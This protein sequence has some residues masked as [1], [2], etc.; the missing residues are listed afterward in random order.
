MARAGSLDR[1]ASAMAEPSWPVPSPP[2]RHPPLHER[3]VSRRRHAPRRRRA[4][5]RPRAR[6]SLRKRHGGHRPRSPNRNVRPEAL[7]IARTSEP[8]VRPPHWPDPSGLERASR[9]RG[10]RMTTAAIR[11]WAPVRSTPKRVVIARQEPLLGRLHV[12]FPR[13]ATRWTGRLSLFD[14][15][16][17]TASSRRAT[18]I[19]LGSPRASPAPRPDL[20]RRP[21][22]GKNAKRWRSGRR[23]AGVATSVGSSTAEAAAMIWSPA[24]TARGFIPGQQRGHSIGKKAETSACD[25]AV[26]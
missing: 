17:K 25:M 13:W 4:L 15:A 14:L 1:Q 23:W 9:Q 21:D 24:A 6:E 12:H 7:E 22:R 5:C 3:L 8:R 19:G 10:G 18:G 26:R 20:D 16:G 2:R 11:S